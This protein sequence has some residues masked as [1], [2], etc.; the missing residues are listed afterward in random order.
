[1]KRR[2]FLK[3]GVAGL[4]GTVA[5]GVS[6][7]SWTTRAYSATVNVSLNIVSGNVLM[8][9]DTSVPMFGFSTTNTIQYPGPTILCQEGDSIVV[10]LTNT[11]NT[12][13]SFKVEGTGI[14]QTLNAG[15][16]RSFSFNAP[17]AGSYLYHDGLNGGVN[18]VMGLH[19]ALVVMPK[20]ISNRSFATGP[21]FVRQYKWI[22][23][24]VDPVWAAAIAANG[25]GHLASPSL[26]VDTFKPRY[27]TING[28]SYARSENYNTK[29]SGDYGEPA[30]IRML[31]AGMVT[32]SPHFHANHVDVISINRQNFAANLQKKKDVVSMFALD[33]RDVIFPFVPP[34]DAWPPATGEQHFPM[35]CHAEPSQTAGG[36]MYPHGLH[37]AIILGRK[38][39]QEPKL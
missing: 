15:E 33:A 30:L 34:P 25:H 38:P 1:M 24:N 22:F 39:A 17:A 32:H 23:G 36:G 10:S 11:L 16:S 18:R 35:H 8:I 27:F 9:D 28:E 12:R 2:D 31:N 7:L 21:T 26:N 37:T 19:G 5:G 13:S 20:G 4:S 29:V 3:I 6:L 14:N